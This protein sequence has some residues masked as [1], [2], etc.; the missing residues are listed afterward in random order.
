MLTS[1][2][3]R[4]VALALPPRCPACG[5]VTG[6]DH[7]FCVDCWAALR[8]L[9][10]PWCAGCALP[11][12]YDRGADTQCP[13]CLSDP[14][15]HRGVRA[16]VAYGDVA[17]DVVLKLKYGRRLGHAATIA[18]LLVRHLPE[19]ADLIVPVPLHRWRIWTRGYNQ[20]ALIATALGSAG[21]RRVDLHAIKRT[22]ATPVLRGLGRSGRRKALAGA[23]AITRRETVA[24]RHVALIDDV[25]TTG[26][27]ADACTAALRRAGAASVTILCWAR[28]LGSEDG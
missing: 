9:G 27:T 16:A 12:E 4:I 22:K 13:Q 26:A 10:P 3:A 19:E 5:A 6:A 17:R 1:L 23:F 2:P 14:P 18:R 11:F 8:F 24:G 28:V 20:S 21:A 7:R 25:Y 15:R